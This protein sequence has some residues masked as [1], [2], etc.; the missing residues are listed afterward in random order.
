MR[1]I[2]RDLLRTG[3][4]EQHL[5]IG[6]GCRRVAPAKLAGLDARHRRA[7][8]QYMVGL[9][10]SGPTRRKTDDYNS[11]PPV[12]TP[13]RLVERIAADRVEDHIRTSTIRAT[14]PCLRNRRDD[15]S[16]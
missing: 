14:R 15:Y 9:C 3:P 12:E 16:R 11:R 6:F 8:D 2:G 5:E 10:Q 7:L 13:H 1:D 4:I